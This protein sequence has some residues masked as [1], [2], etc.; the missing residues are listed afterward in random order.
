MKNLIFEESVIAEPVK[1]LTNAIT[2]EIYRKKSQSGTMWYSLRDFYDYCTTNNIPLQGKDYNMLFFKK[3]YIEYNLEEYGNSSSRVEPENDPNDFVVDYG[4][5]DI[6]MMKGQT[7]E[8]V[9]HHEIAHLYQK[10]LKIQKY[11]RKNNPYSNQYMRKWGNVYNKAVNNFNSNNNCIKILS[12]IYYYL[13]LQEITAYA[14]S[15]Y[16]KILNN[17]ELDPYQTPEWQNL[18]ELKEYQK[19]ILNWNE[20]D[21]E[22]EEAKN[23]FF[24]KTTP[25][26]EFKYSVKSF[27]EH[28][29][30]IC[31]TKFGKAITKGK[32]D[33]VT[34]KIIE[35]H[36]RER[37]IQLLN[38]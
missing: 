3:I 34:K 6:K 19:I 1:I 18:V 27:L 8:S 31:D 37:V 10:M 23:L 22:V 26:K 16:N 14:N 28:R 29:L 2:E 20:N 33:V 21:K 25:F 32:K 36:I 24:G 15:L 38:Q 4:V 35:K 11:N 12:N 7:F 13:S 9:L 17:K 5:L 30:K